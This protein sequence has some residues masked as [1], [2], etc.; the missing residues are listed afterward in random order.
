MTKKWPIIKDLCRI[1]LYSVWFQRKR[2]KSGPSQDP[3]LL[4]N[5]LTKEILTKIYLSTPLRVDNG[6][7]V[8]KD[9]APSSRHRSSE[10][11]AEKDT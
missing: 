8:P 4:E 1:A 6:D 10:A 11:K 7:G 5:A 2:P 3:A 9:H